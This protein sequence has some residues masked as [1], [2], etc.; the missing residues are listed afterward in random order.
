M[1]NRLEKANY[2]CKNTKQGNILNGGAMIYIVILD[3]V[4]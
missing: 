2:S 4:S 1:Y 3:V